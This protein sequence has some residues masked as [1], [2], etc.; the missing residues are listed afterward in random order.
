MLVLLDNNSN[1]GLGPAHGALLLILGLHLRNTRPPLI[2][3][4]IHTAD[5]RALAFAHSGV[6]VDVLGANEHLAV[7]WVDEPAV[8][9]PHE[10]EHDYEGPGHVEFEEDLGIE[11]RSADRVEGDV[12]LGD[13]GDDVDED[14]DVRAPYAEG[15]FEWQLV[16]R[17]AVV[18]PGT[19]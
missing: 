13:E 6:D 3:R 10:V 2:L 7:L 19:L 9:L 14:A 4:H 5:H 8:H 16:D 17:V 15:G 11:V 12:E 18:S 1:G